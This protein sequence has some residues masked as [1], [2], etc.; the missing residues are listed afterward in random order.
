M[1]QLLQVTPFVFPKVTHSDSISEALTV[2]ID[3]SKNGK[4]TVVIHG[5][6]QVIDTIYTSAQLVELCGALKV[7]ELVALPFNLYSDSHYVVRALQV[8]E[9]VPSIQPSTA[10]F[11]MFFKIQML[12]RAHAHPFFAGHIRTQSSLPSPLTEGNYLADQATRLMCLASLSDLLSEAKTAHALHHLNAHTLRL[13]YKITREQ[14]RQIVKQCKNCLTLLP[15]PHLG[16][17]PRGLISGELWQMDVTHVPSFGKLR[18]VH[19]TV[20]TFSGFICASAHMGEATKDVINHLLYVFSVMGQ[21]KM[22]KT[23]NGPGYT[24]QKFKQF[25]SQLQIKHITGIPYNPQGQGL[26]ERAHQT[27]KNT[28]IKL[29]TQETIYSF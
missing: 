6:I 23:D 18:F 10:T 12:I 1:L 21:P 2:F 13:R 11:Q 22:I 25:C 29:A 3:G 5:Q 17:S 19:V 27:L 20:D 14:A 9:V 7:F 26:V 28:L 24:S 4:A 15:E 16:V 8:L